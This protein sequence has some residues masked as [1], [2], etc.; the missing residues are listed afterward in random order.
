MNEVVRIS[1][2]LRSAY[3]GEAWHGPSLRRSAHDVSAPLRGQTAGT[4]PYYLGIVNHLAAWNG[5]SAPAR[6]RAR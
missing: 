1:R 2:Q 3:K 4:C 5:A 6:R